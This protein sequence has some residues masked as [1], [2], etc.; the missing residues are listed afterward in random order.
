[1]RQDQTAPYLINSYIYKYDKINAYAQ[2]SFSDP[3]ANYNPHDPAYNPIES[4]TPPYSQEQREQARLSVSDLQL[5]FSVNKDGS[6]YVTINS[7]EP[8]MTAG[9]TLPP[10]AVEYYETFKAIAKQNYDGD[11]NGYY[12]IKATA[13]SGYSYIPTTNITIRTLSDYNADY[14]AGSVINNIAEVMWLSPEAFLLSGSKN[15]RLEDGCFWKHSM[16]LDKFNTPNGG[17]NIVD[18]LS[19]SLSLNV[20]P[21]AD[22]IYQFEITH[23]DAAGQTQSATTNP[24]GISS[25]ETSLKDVVF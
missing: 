13:K 23:T 5:G 1:M 8:P 2:E 4:M 9:A 21:Q 6:G 15:K 10:N 7:T 20:S 12:W 19:F 3:N 16:P 17:A 24:I 25:G 14:P 22:G 11:Y 18:G